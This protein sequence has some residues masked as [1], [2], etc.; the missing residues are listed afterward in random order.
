MEQ[1][2]RIFNEHAGFVWAPIILGL[3]GYLVYEWWVRPPG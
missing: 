2:L 3:V 1:Y